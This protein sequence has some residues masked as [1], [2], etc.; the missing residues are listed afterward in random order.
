ML[1]VG[2]AAFIPLPDESVHCVVTS[3]PYWSLR[4]YEGD[5]DAGRFP[6]LGLEDTPEEYLDRMVIIFREVWRVLRPDGVVFLNIAD[7]FAS[8]WA[9]GR[10]NII[11]NPSRTNRVDR[12]TETIYR[13]GDLCMIPQRLAIA[14][15]QDGWL[16]RRDYIWHKLNPAPEN[17]LGW[18]WE[19]HR[20]KID[21][22]NADWKSRPKGWQAGLGA[23]DS[24]SDSKGQY[25]HEQE[26]TVPVYIDCPGCEKC[27]HDNP[28]FPD[29]H[30]LRLGSWRHT[31]SHE[32]VWMM[33][34][35]MKYY[36]DQ[37]AVKEPTT[38][39]AHPHG[40]GI[41]K[42][43][44][45]FGEGVRAN[46]SFSEAI[47]NETKNDL[48]ETR[49]PRSVVTINGFNF[50]DLWS[51]FIE[52]I[53]NPKDIL[54]ISTENYPGAHYAVYTPNLVAPLIMAACP[55]HSCPECG[56]AWAPVVIKGKYNRHQSKKAAELDDP[57][58]PSWRYGTAQDGLPYDGAGNLVTSYAP[59]CDCGCEESVP[60]IVLDPFAGTGTTGM[61]AKEL[62]RRW[63]AMDISK[64]YLD[65]QA[66]YRTKW[67]EQK[68]K[69]D[70]LPLFSELDKT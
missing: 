43:L 68:T 18:R 20:I 49:N 61:V 40:S 30:V 58:S 27:L 42:K 38:G 16:I 35:Q 36:C 45:D 10:R 28:L 56:Q 11:G 3:P 52:S 70:D 2:D 53:R 60:G 14:L 47:R 62:G 5:Q 32:Y 50:D 17:L 13:E 63:V 7:T 8:S 26:Q 65:D 55:K 31:T 25:R 41:G 67:G 33:T 54:S 57:D 4:K 6:N 69:V 39:G 15:Q 66:R 9:S 51:L 24:G 19:R 1:I 46:R 21:R 12:T 64:P 59:T 44:I 48:P 34:K 22:E 29:L 37:E 23:H